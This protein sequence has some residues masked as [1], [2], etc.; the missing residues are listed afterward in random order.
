M[1]CSARSDHFYQVDT[2]AGFLIAFT[3]ALGFV[4]L[5]AT[6]YELFWLPHLINAEEDFR[7][8]HPQIALPQP[9]KHYV[10]GQLVSQDDSAAAQG[11]CTAEMKW[12]QTLRPEHTAWIKETN[13]HT[14]TYKAVK[15]FS[16]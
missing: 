2:S 10:L 8:V 4:C 6:L 3:A 1:S 7:A 9:A 11:I 13:Y 5:S 16:M 14:P 12:I 15:M